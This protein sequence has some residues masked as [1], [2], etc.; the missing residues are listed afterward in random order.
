MTFLENAAKVAKH[1]LEYDAGMHTFN[2]ELNALADMSE[3]EYRA[4][5]L[6]T[7]RP[8][9]VHRHVESEIVDSVPAAIDWRDY[10]AVTPVKDQGQCGSCWSFG[11]T[12]ALEGQFFLK[13]GTLL[14]FSEQQ[15]VDCDYYCYGCNGGNADL[16]FTYWK[17]NHGPVL[18]KTYP[19]TAQQGNCKNYPAVTTVTG[20]VDVTS[21]SETALKNAVGSIGPVTVA[22]DAS[23]NSFQFY[24]SG[25][26]NPTGCSTTQLD[27]QVLTVG[28]DH[29]STGGDYWIVKNSWGTSWGQQGYIWIA[30]NQGNVCGIATDGSYPKL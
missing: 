4:A 1:N 28:Y 15:L 2:I 23:K 17:R 29:A 26:Y 14:S 30:R 27:H 24:K 18:E 8:P 13:N 25:V 21:G 9:M 6:M 3:E 20:Y 22:I 19:Y 5:L 12:G 11:S 7:A 10:G 16:A